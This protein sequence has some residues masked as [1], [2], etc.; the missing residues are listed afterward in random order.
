MC[1]ILA[2]L[3]RWVAPTPS[4]LWYHALTPPNNVSMI[5]T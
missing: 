5:K 2:H 3:T 4:K 1:I